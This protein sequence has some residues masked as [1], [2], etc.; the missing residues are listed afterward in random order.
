MVSSARLGVVKQSSFGLTG[1]YGLRV[2]RANYLAEG[3]VTIMRYI[4]L[5][6]IYEILFS[7]FDPNLN[8]IGLF[9]DF[10]R[11]RIIHIPSVVCASR[12]VNDCRF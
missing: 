3:V 10:K 9:G 2:T 12:G 5:V 7:L 11:D 1:Q 6:I 8:I 4:A